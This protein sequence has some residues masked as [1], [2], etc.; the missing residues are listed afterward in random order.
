MRHVPQVVS[1][2]ENEVG[3]RVERRADLAESAVAASALQTVLVPVQ[4][5]RLQK[6]P[7]RVAT[8]S[9]EKLIL[10]RSADNVSCD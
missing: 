2:A 7:G 10:K 5:Q 9:R 8:I 4:V 3:L 1:F 6:V